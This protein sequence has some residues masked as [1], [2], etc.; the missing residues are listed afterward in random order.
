MK[1]EETVAT[2]GIISY[3]SNLNEITSKKNEK[4]DQIKMRIFDEKFST[5][6]IILWADNCKIPG[7]KVGNIIS[8]S[9]YKLGEYLNTKNLSAKNF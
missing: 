6:Q 7:L 2:S 9:N 3:V 8:L 1:N 4:I 5:I